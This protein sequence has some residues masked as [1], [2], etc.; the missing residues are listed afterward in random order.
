MAGLQSLRPG[1]EQM[2]AEAMPPEEMPN[3]AASEDGEEMANVSPEEQAI[4]E[5]SVRNALNLIYQEGGDKHV[6]PAVLKA[7]KSS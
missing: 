1:A 6:S 5:Q 3:Q 2:P 4:Y 7:L